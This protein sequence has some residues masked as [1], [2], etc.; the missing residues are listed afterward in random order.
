VPTAIVIDGGRR[1]LRPSIG[2]GGDEPALQLVRERWGMDAELPPEAP[3]RPRALCAPHARPASAAALGHACTGVIA[4]AAPLTCEEVHDGEGV[5]TAP[6]AG[7]DA[8][9]A[10]HCVDGRCR[11]GCASDADCALGT[12]C[13]RGACVPGEPG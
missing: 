1:T 12:L 10:G 9:G 6:C 2:V 4:C 5:C 8:C 7:D 3:V 11:A 13:A